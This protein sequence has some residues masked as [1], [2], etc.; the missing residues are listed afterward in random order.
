MPQWKR[1]LI[2]RLQSKNARQQLCAKS[3]QTDE[4]HSG[5][6]GS[7]SKRAIVSGCSTVSCLGCGDCVGGRCALYV[8]S[9]CNNSVVEMVQER[10][11]SD[12]ETTVKNYDLNNGNKKSDSEEST[13]DLQYGP[14]I[15]NKL[16]N[17][18]LNLTLRELNGKNRPSILNLRKAT[19]LEHLLDDETPGEK[20]RKDG[21]IFEQRHHENEVKTRYHRYQIKAAPYEIKRARSVEAISQ[22]VT[23]NTSYNIENDIKFKRES[24]NEDMLIY[25]EEGNEETRKNDKTTSDNN[26]NG[27]LHHKN[28]SNNVSS[29]INRPLRIKPI[30]NEREKPPADVVKETKK[31]FERP[32]LRTKQVQHTGEVAAKVATY[33]NIIGQTKQT[34]GKKPPLKQKPVLIIDKK[35]APITKQNSVDNT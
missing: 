3:N 34:A 24:L 12:L 16:K 25:R 4:V 28:T 35:K 21:R 8:K 5:F 6:I 17:R 15:V 9:T 19:S 33:K 22:T 20:A 30:M 32:E 29:R 1:D 7:P 2:Q 18:Y 23:N 11:W 26:M 14:G 13:E 31:L 10:K 27:I